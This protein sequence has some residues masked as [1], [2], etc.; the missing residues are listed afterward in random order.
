M[1]RVERDGVVLYIERHWFLSLFFFTLAAG[2]LLGA[3]FNPPGR[4]DP[5]PGFFYALGGGLFIAAF[6]FQFKRR[7]L[8]I[9]P[10]LGM[11]LILDRLSVFT[12]RRKEVP[13]RDLTVRT[14]SLAARGELSFGRSL[15]FIWIDIPGRPSILF[16]GNITDRMK[17]QDA[18]TQLRQDLQRPPL[19][20]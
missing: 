5:P 1:N 6:I 12:L 13:L 20:S 16:Q 4:D 19:S 17:F 8:L 14:S 15:N 7:A 9:D 2:I 10:A 18:V 11:L 3:Y